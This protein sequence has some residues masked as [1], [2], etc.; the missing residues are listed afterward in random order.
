MT[1]GHV[2]K[3]LS[4]PSF[5]A[6]NAL[7][8]MIELNEWR[9]P[10]WLTSVRDGSDLVVAGDYGG[11]HQGAL[12]RVYSIL[13]ADSSSGDE[14]D[15]ARTKTRLEVLRDG[16]EM[17]Y[18]KLNDAVR[19]RALPQF[20]KDGSL[21]RG[22]LLNLLVRAALRPFQ[23]DAV[24]PD[25]L[26]VETSGLRPHTLD[27]LSLVAHIGG[28]LLSCV[29]KEGQNVLWVSDQDEIAPNPQRHRIAS[30]VLA[31]ISSHYLRHDLSNY[32]KTILL[33]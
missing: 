29:S 15:D 23:P 2:W 20:F 24:E 22:M 9:N 8:E 27:R 10:G 31:N 14:W 19:A 13:I 16:R 7:S 5:G 12:Y 17:A 26:V 4:A 32:L 3:H 6:I 28:M 21:Q 18:K 1:A 30:N 25:S 33:I 11:D